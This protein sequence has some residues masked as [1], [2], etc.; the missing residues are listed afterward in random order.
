MPTSMEPRPVVP[1]EAA[2]LALPLGHR[3]LTEQ[4]G[5]VPMAVEEDEALGCWCMFAPCDNDDT[6]RSWWARL[7]GPPGTPCAIPM[8]KPEASPSQKRLS[9]VA[10]TAFARA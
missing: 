1:S 7:R 4:L 9:P 2:Q 5:G 6:W 10:N 3:H 8:L